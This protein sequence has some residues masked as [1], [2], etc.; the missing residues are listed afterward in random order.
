MLYLDESEFLDYGTAL[1]ASFCAKSACMPFYHTCIFMQGC[2]ESLD[3]YVRQTSTAIG[4]TGLS[5]GVVEVNEIHLP[6][7]TDV[8]V[9][10]CVSFMHEAAQFI[11]YLMNKH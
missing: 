8:C 6:L 1:F 4:I 11:K 2:S 10:V 5:L 3:N 7:Q 9:C